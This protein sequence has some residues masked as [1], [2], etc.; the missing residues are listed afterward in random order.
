MYSYTHTLLK[1]I[2]FE[3]CF[4]VFVNN[5]QYDILAVHKVNVKL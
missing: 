1:N 3:D 2:N 5:S 4:N